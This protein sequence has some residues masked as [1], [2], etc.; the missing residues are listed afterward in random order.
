L[1]F[2]GTYHVAPRW[3]FQANGQLR[4]ANFAAEAEQLWL[5]FG[6]NYDVTQGGGVNVGAGYI[7]L[8]TSPYGVFPSPTTFPENRI[9]EQLVINS[10]L[11]L[12]GLEQRFQLEQR[13]VSATSTQPTAQ[14]WVFSWRAR[15]LFG[16][17]IPFHKRPIRP[18]DF[19]AALSDEIFIAFGSNVTSLFNQNRAYVQ[20]GWQASASVRLLGGYLNQIVAKGSTG[21]E[22]EINHVLVLSFYHSASLR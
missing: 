4:R 2:Y 12:V 6:V 21:N 19:Y 15:G 10:K 17:T 14:G 3:S 1:Q 18:G 9:W 20:L 13:W 22:T 11:G 5:M 7:Y 8:R 16:A